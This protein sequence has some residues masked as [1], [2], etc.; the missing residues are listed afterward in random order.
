MLTEQL[1]PRSTD[2]LF[3][4]WPDIPER[5]FTF[6][7]LKLQSANPDDPA[8]DTYI[9]VLEVNR[10][11]RTVQLGAL[12]T[13]DDAPDPDEIIGVPLA[14][15]KYADD[16]DWKLE[17]TEPERIPNVISLLVLHLGVH[18]QIGEEER[19][20]DG[21]GLLFAGEMAR[22]EKVLVFDEQGEKLFGGQ[23]IEVVMGEGL[24]D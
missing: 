5:S 18:F 11:V 2:I 6:R 17:L 14:V 3:S 22:G 8:D 12:A 10:S 4:L 13:G 9:A 15:G 16:D 24:V 23:G 21:E 19:G 20:V 1:T 7:I